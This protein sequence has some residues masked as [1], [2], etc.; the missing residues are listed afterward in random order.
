MSEWAAA[1]LAIACALSPEAAEA[2]LAR[3]LTLVQRLPG[4]LAALEAGALHPGHLWPLLEHVA[5][6]A[7]DRLRAEVEAGLLR[8]AAGRMT[9]PAQLGARARREVA[10]SDARAAAR[11]LE[12]AL[13]RRGIYRGGSAPDGLAAIT[14]LLTEPEAQVFYRALGGY[15][16]AID[17]DPDHPRSRAQKMADCLLDLVLRP[18]GLDL[19]RVRLLLTVVA[20]VGTLAGGDEPGEV[21]GRLVSPEE[22]RELIRLF[23]PAAPAGRGG[24]RGCCPRRCARGRRPRPDGRASTSSPTPAADAAR[25]PVPVVGDQSSAPRRAGRAG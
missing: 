7:E 21:D 2:L 8:W 1:E 19:V 18:G 4:T 22:I 3:S 6:I 23:G 15:A 12:R 25:R 17:D 24:P 13:R 9:T 14:L 5:P 16:D 10:R 20:S 11:R